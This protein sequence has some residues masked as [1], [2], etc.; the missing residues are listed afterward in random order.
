MFKLS[1]YLIVILALIVSCSDSSSSNDEKR[2]AS[3]E[4]EGMVCEMGC[5][6]SLR[7]GLYTTDAVDEVKVEYKEERKQNLIHVYYSSSKTNPKDMLKIIEGLNEGQFAAKIV[8]DKLVPAV[9]AKSDSESSSA[10]SN[11]DM[12]G[13]EASTKSFS[14]PN[15]TELINSLIY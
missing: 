9:K 8:D 13:V 7:K 15:L 6:A 4:I 12:N 11:N 1:A 3:F 2:V 5:G 10:S 14:L